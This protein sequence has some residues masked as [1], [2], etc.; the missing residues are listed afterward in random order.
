[1]YTAPLFLLFLA[2]IIWLYLSKF[3]KK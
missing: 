3:S 1:P 2:G